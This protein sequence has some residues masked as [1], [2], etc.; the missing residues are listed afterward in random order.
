MDH[1]WIVLTISSAILL[2]QQMQKTL[3]NARPILILI[4]PDLSGNPLCRAPQDHLAHTYFGGST[5]RTHIAWNSPEPTQTMPALALDILP[6]SFLHEALQKHLCLCQLWL[7]WSHQG[8][9]LQ[10]APH[11]PLACICFRSSYPTTERPR[12]P[13]LYLPQLL[14]SHIDGLYA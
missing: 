7:Q 9:S 1:F 5:Q 14:L 13:T 3:R 11:R 10:G 2:W 12:T 4:I 6:R 8:T